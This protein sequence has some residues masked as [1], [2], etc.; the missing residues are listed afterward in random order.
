MMHYKVMNLVWLIMYLIRPVSSYCE[1]FL[2]VMTVMS[3]RGSYLI[4]NLW[5]V[6]SLFVVQ[7]QWDVV[8]VRTIWLT[9]FV[10]V[11]FF[12]FATNN[13]LPLCLIRFIINKDSVISQ[14]YSIVRNTLIFRILRNW[15]KKCRMESSWR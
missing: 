3:V 4:L 15:K 8:D 12:N 13:T 2:S 9:C 14:K 11:T 1:V 5:C 7:C 10:S 6:L